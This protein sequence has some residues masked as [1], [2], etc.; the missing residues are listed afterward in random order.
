MFLVTTADRSTVGK[1]DD[2]VVNVETSFGSNCFGSLGSIRK[3]CALHLKNRDGNPD[4]PAVRS[5]AVETE[6]TQATSMICDELHYGV[7]Q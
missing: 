5:A 6:T 4:A 7:A 1:A 2:C 3:W